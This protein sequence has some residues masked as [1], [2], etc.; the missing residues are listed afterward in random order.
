MS[1]QCHVPAAVDPE[2]APP[3]SVAKEVVYTE[4]RSNAVDKRNILTL[5]GNRS[6]IT[7]RFRLLS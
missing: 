2:E 3:K 6:T 7:E 5:S 1:D 4:G